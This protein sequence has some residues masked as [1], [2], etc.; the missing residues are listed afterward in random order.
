MPFR[1]EELEISGVVLV[2]PKVFPDDRG[3][4]TETYKYSDFAAR[5]ISEP[6]LQDNHSFSAKGT[7]RGLHYQ[8]APKSQGKLVRVV[9]GEVFD[10]AVDLLKDSPTFGKWVGVTLSAENKNMLY[11]P[12]W[13]AH[14]FVVTSNE[15]DV[16]Y[17]VTAEYSLEHEA[18][19]LW[20]DP[21]LGIAWPEKR[22][23]LSSKDC[24]W[25]R[26]RDS[27]RLLEFQS[28]N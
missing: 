21:D 16:V 28:H 8:T 25:P 22:P 12:P 19:I 10:V 15:A 17:K 2:E 13:C 6:F 11:I 9:A 18:G 20:D 23:I 3:F 1:F 4:F 26:L 5:G 14:G 27:E 24:M 7:L